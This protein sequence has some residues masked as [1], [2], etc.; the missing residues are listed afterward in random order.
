MTRRIEEEE[1]ERE[2]KKEN[3]RESGLG[4]TEMRRFFLCPPHDGDRDLSVDHCLDLCLSLCRLVCPYHLVCPCPCL[5]LCLCL[6]A[7][8]TLDG[9]TEATERVHVHDA[10]TTRNNGVDYV[11]EN[12]SESESE[13][14]KRMEIYVNEML[15]CG[16]NGRRVVVCHRRNG[17]RVYRAARS[18]RSQV[19]GR[20]HD[21][22]PCPHHCHSH[23]QCLSL[24]AHTTFMST[25]KR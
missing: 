17:S 24:C 14:E 18:C 22:L 21:S 23:S 3:E 8:E 4:G 9:L 10:T 2:R 5:C 7:I 6:N 20:H 25:M 12:V 19:D 16:E 1:S 15:M 13:N 11:M